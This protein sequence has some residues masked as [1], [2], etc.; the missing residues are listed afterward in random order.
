MNEISH[1][2]SFIDQNWQQTKITW[3]KYLIFNKIYFHPAS[4]WDNQFIYV[5]NPSL[6]LS[7]PL[8]F[9]KKSLGM[10]TSIWFFISLFFPLDPRCSVGKL[11]RA[12]QENLG[13]KGSIH[14]CL[15]GYVFY[16]LLLI[17]DVCLGER[18]RAGIITN[19]RDEK[20]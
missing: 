16:L 15:Y 6:S 10:F 5:I 3:V 2:G 14:W 18:E 20:Y 8:L 17:L 7:C 13:L 1:V 12:M 4:C 9:L 11:K 19:G